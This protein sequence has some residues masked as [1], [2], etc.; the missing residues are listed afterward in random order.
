[1][2]PSRTRS[3]GPGSAHPALRT[4]YTVTRDGPPIDI[5]DDSG[6]LIRGRYAEVTDRVV[7]DSI[8]E[9]AALD[10]ADVLLHDS[11]HTYEHETTEYETV[12]LHSNAVVLSDNAHVTAA[13]PDWAERTGHRFLFF[14]ERPA[15]HWY[16]GSG[17]GAAW[18]P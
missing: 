2:R 17:I 12:Q 16:P 13:L 14:A 6:Y 3:R 7:G 18:R 10:T 9:L 8:R 11:L 15:R 5:N 4:A 1:M